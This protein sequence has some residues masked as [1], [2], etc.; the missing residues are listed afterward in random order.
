LFCSIEPEVTSEP[1]K[2]TSSTN[3]PKAGSLAE[4]LKNKLRSQKLNDGSDVHVETSQ[5]VVT[6]TTKQR[7]KRSPFPEDGS[8]PGN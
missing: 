6:R 7:Q 8:E 3:K 1:V 4:K 2:E 5:I